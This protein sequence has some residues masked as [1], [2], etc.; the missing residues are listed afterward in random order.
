[1]WL[2]L[3]SVFFLKILGLDVLSASY[4]LIQKKKYLLFLM[5]DNILGSISHGYYVFDYHAYI[6]KN[7]IG[8]PYVF[9]YKTIS[10]E[11]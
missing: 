9:Y 1:V 4:V 5:N 3:R 11:S 6:K 8:S 7:I 10:M 2:F